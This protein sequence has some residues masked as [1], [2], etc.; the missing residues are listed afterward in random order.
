[1]P[2]WLPG[3]SIVYSSIRGSPPQLV[4]RDLATGRE[5]DLLPGGK[6]QGAHD[7]SPDGKT[8]LYGERTDFFHVWTLPLSGGR[9]PVPFLQAPFEKVEARFSP[10]G[11]YISMITDESGRPEAYV[12]AYPGPGERIRVSTGGAR[13]PRWSRDGRELYYLSGDRRLMSVAVRTAPS[14]ELGRPQ[15]LFELEGKWSWST[16]EVSPDGKR[17]LA[18]VPEV[19][20]DELP[21]SV[22][23]NWAAEAGK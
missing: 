23:V 9:K 13:S 19:V 6:M 15:P 14:L 8:L 7:V 1:M 11:R 10:D 3:G 5:E 22:V 17:F 16:F 21:V 12:T 18:I 2:R 20:A 4:R